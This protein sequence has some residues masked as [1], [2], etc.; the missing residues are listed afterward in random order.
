MRVEVKPFS[1]NKAW[2]GRRYKT[3]EYTYW[4]NHLCLILPKIDIPDGNFVIYLRFGIY[5]KLA[6]FDNPVKPFV[7]ALQQRYGFNDRQIKQALIEV[8]NVP[9]KG[10]EY[11]EFEIIDGK[12][13]IRS[14]IG[15]EN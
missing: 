15:I 3:N 4:R 1:V 12:I 9:K 8:D 14:M 5:S 11:I 2:K 7:D 13:D 10:D 6:D